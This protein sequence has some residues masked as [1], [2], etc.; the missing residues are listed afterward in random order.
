MSTLAASLLNELIR[1]CRKCVFIDK[2]YVK[3]RA[4][5]TW[6]PSTVEVLIV[7]E[8]PPPSKKEDFFYNLSAF[9]R[10]R[11]SMKTILNLRSLKGE[12]LLGFLRERGV[13]LTSA[14]KCRPPSKADVPGMRERC[15]W[16]LRR[17]LELLK[18]RRLL[19]M[20]KTAA[21][22]VFEILGLKPP[23]SV[24]GIRRFR[25]CGLELY[26]TPHPNFIFRFK[27]ELA[28]EVKRLIELR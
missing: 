16:V 20:G 1:S 13:F 28:G 11:L 19:A 6:L 18:P 24:V 23:S 4:Y 14:V 12:E 26:V 9:D 5:T 27:R 3:Y 2:P 17:E 22:S 10:L 25:A 7:A 21:T 15:T 8:S